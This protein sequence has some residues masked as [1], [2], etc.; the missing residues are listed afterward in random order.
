MQAREKFTQRVEFDAAEKNHRQRHQGLNGQT[1][2]ET[3][4]PDIVGK[5]GQEDGHRSNQNR[6]KGKKRDLAEN[7]V[8][9][10]GRTDENGDQPET[11]NEGCAGGVL[12]VSARAVHD[13][14]TRG[15][16]DAQSDHHTGDQQTNTK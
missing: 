2:F 15:Q 10:Q 4:V 6:G 3:Q 8:A 13:P 16:T 7:R 11:A 5:A 9:K 12:F 14:E 1:W